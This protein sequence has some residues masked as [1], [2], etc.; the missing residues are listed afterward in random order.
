MMIYRKPRDNGAGY[1]LLI[2]N[3]GIVERTIIYR[4]PSDSGADY[5]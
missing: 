5:Y 3:P 1:L 2:V 4:N